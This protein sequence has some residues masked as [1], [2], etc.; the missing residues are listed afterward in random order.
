VIFAVGAPGAMIGA[1]VAARLARWLGLGPTIIWS[2][3]LGGVGG[4]LIP[5]ASGPLLIAVPLLIAA[6][7]L[8]GLAFVV[9]NVNQISLRQ[10]ITPDRL[11]GRMTATIRFMVWGTLP[12]GS[13]LGGALGSMLGVRPTLIIGGIGMMLA[14][15]WVLFSPIRTLRDQPQIAAEPSA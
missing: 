7:F 9:Y 12:F 3:V 14:F 10:A 5:L 15:L 8:I 4:L 2:A 13:L 1:F 6:Q 11:L